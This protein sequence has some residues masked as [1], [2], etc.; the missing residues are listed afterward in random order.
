MTNESL[1]DIDS[2]RFE[3]PSGENDRSLAKGVDMNYSPDT[4]K[5]VLAGDNKFLH[6][7]TI[8]A[9]TRNGL[10]IIWCTSYSS[11]ECSFLK[12]R[13][14]QQDFDDT[15]VVNLDDYLNMQC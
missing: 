8:R 11:W 9:E 15:Q 5:C 7:P 1:A 13:C 2:D 14:L 3:E 6:L 12:S 10:I 4:L